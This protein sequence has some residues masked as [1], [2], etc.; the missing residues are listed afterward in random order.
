[1][2]NAEHL[3]QFLISKEMP[4]PAYDQCIKAS[5]FLNLLD[6]RGVIGINERMSYINRVR[7]L[8]NAC[9]TLY[10]KQ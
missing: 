1:F 9:C 2:E 7:K 3:C 10:I 4:F 6:A 8:T 5:H